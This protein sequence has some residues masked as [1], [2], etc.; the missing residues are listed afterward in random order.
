LSL[1]PREQPVAA[2]GAALL[3]RTDVPIP[4]QI[5]AAVPAAVAAETT[6]DVPA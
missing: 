2:V 5:P 1:I 4:D 6:E 3:A